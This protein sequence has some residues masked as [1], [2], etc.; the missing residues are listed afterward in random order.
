MSVS[1][2]AARREPTPE[3]RAAIATRDRDVLLEAGAGTGKTGVLVDRYCDAVELDGVSPDGILAFTFTDRAAAQLRGRIRDE[4]DRRAGA[5][6][7]TEVSQRLA[8]TLSEFGGAWI[9]TIHGFCRRLLANH[10]VAAGIDPR[11]RVLDAAEADRVARRAFDRALEEFLATADGDR[12]LTVATYGIDQLRSLVGDAHAELRSRGEADPE[13]PEPPPSDLGAALARVEATAAAALAEGAGT[14]GQPEKIAAALELARRREERLP[15][16][17]ELSPLCIGSKAAGLA[18]FCAAMT[19]ARARAAEIEF[20]AETYS[21]VRELLRLF[22]RRYGEAKAARSGLDFED[23]QLL[24][25]RLLRESEPVRHAHHDRFKHLMVDEFQDTNKLQLALIEALSGPETTR[26]AV[27][28]E[29]QS[30]YGFRHADLAVFRQERERF[31]ER[32]GAEV[33]PLSGN[34]RARP[35]LIAASN[36]IGEVLLGDLNPGGFSPLTVGKPPEDPQPRGG[37]PAVELLV[38]EADGWDAEDIDLALPVDDRT[39]PEAVAEA[40]ALAERLRELADAGVPRGDMV[41]LLRALSKVDAFEEALDRAGLAPYVVGGRGYWSQQ[42]VEDLLCLL[43]AIANP[44]DDQPLL[45]ALASPAGGIG[46]DTLWLLRRATGAKRP[47]WPAVERAVGAWEPDLEDSERLEQIEPEQRE[48]L[49]AFHAHVA[50][51]R[52]AG[53][54]LA[55]EEL[56]DRAVRI[57][58]Y[59]LAILRQR[60]GEQRMANVR[61]LMRLAREFEAAEGRDLRG[62]LDFAALRAAADDEPSAAT[63]A[64]DHDGVRILTIH[65]A[66]GLEFPV[67]AVADLGRDLLLGGWPPAL[68]IGRGDPPDIGMRLARL[69]SDNQPIYAMEELKKGD[70][71]RE[72]AE[73]LR[74]FY[75]AATRAQERLILSGVMAASRNGARLRTPIVRRLPGVLGVDE[76]EDGQVVT[77]PVP[78]PRDGLDAGFA[79]PE[80]LVRVNRASLARAAEL[81][82][83]SAAENA[84]PA[85]AAAAPPLLSGTAT[86]ASM[87]PLSYSR[88]GEYQRCGYRFYVER[89]LGLGAV[90][91]GNGLGPGE[92][93]EQRFGFGSAVHGMLEWSARN[94]WVEPGSALAARFLAAEGLEASGEQAERA[95]DQVRGWLGSDLCSELRDG[96]RVRPEVPFLLDLSGALVRGSIDLLA[97]P[98]AGPPTLVDFKTDRLQ[99]GD[100][101]AVADRYEVQQLLYAVA[102]V[103]ATGAASVQIAWLFL[104][105]PEAP[106]VAELDAAAIAA[107]RERL[108][109]M[110][111][112]VAAGRFEVTDEPTWE[113]CRDCPARRRLCSRPAT[114]PGG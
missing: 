105:R 38:T 24:A 16:L 114:P 88:L 18:D 103:A 25:V 83:G 70:D 80:V 97:E 64:E 106:V 94:R 78:A 26:F 3:Q 20:G 68:R 28:D 54:R 79:D 13:L 8:R 89:V 52:E 48:R 41:L 73:E 61:K 40:R 99:G 87:P 47:L 81:V 9:T 35:E 6:E 1:T 74:L 86:G 72:A 4:L 104:E 12:E 55:L 14:K 60:L 65:S 110:V 101:A 30:I 92:G 15:S 27:G 22:G 84:A 63:E 23:L 17:A 93:R 75:V 102:A 109:E 77:L 69:G 29:L 19:A 43:S 98:D 113:L 96:G 91:P 107:A 31:R 85:V 10:P 76:L 100:P 111:A 82:G 46:P 58:G 62:F 45:G 53:T 2:A 51:L 44:L 50:S 34:F 5:S 71:E 49:A 108:E 36:R 7:D 112:K 11:F 32:D 59:D 57:T 37:D 67:V 95:L 56:I 39:G 42:Q 90:E 33:L 21:H 66:K